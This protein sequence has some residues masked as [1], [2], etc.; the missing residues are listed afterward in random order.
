MNFSLGYCMSVILSR[1]LGDYEWMHAIS[2]ECE[3]FIL[4]IPD[5]WVIARLYGDIPYDVSSFRDMMMETGWFSDVRII[6][7]AHLN[8]RVMHEEIEFDALWYGTEYGKKFLAD[9]AYLEDR[10]CTLISLE[11]ESYLPVSDGGSLRVACSD[12]TRDQ[13]LIL[14]GAGRYFEA[15]MRDYGSKY[16][17]SYAVDNNP[18]RQGIDVSGVYIDS[19]KRIMNESADDILVVICSR[20]Y[21]A[22]KK[23]IL[24]MGNYDYRT[25]LFFDSVSRLEEFGIAATKEA[26]YIKKDHMI[27]TELMSEFDRVCVENGLRYYFICGSLIGLVR[28]QGMIPWDDDIDLAMPREDYKKLKRIARR[29]WNKD[30]DTFQFIDYPDIGGGVF[31]DCMPRLFYM[32]DHIPVKVFDKVH[33]KATADIEDRA[34][35]DIYVCDRAHKSKIVHNIAIG[36][37]KGIYNMMMGHRPHINYDEYRILIPDRT[38]KLMKVLNTIG[39]AFPMRFLAF[40]YDAFARSGNFNRRATDYIMESCAIRCIELKYPIAHFGEGQ[41]LP[42]ESIEVMAPSDYDAQLHDMRYN[43]YMEFPRMSVRKPSHYFNSDIEIW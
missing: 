16:N 10:G 5:E 19:P 35:I 15:F 14:F 3:K 40:W 34:F 27:L 29:I 13:K 39:K 18:D 37:M 31:L 8:Y 26:E 43:N 41:R 38:I 4:G 23:Q 7:A 21:E 33:G 1:N 17:P 12:L 32:K 11:T 36:A 6:D 9:R 24:E 28:H 22:I 2:D 42:F 25:M 30:N 20:D